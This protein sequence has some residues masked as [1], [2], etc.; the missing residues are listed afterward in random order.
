MRIVCSSWGSSAMSAALAEA[1][2][3]A[4]EL[5]CAVAVVED[6]R[7][8]GGSAEIARQGRPICAQPPP[9]ECLEGAG[10]ERRDATRPVCNDRHPVRTLEHPEKLNTGLVAVGSV[11]HTAVQ[12]PSMR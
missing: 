12:L 10:D 1:W 7:A 4:G 3:M 2:A 6:Q 8:G 9:R 11:P 5:V